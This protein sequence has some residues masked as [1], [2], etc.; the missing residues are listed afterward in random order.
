MTNEG[1]NKL[2]SI[3]TENKGSKHHISK[4]SEL[5]LNLAENNMVDDDFKEQLFHIIRKKV[6]S[7]SD[8]SVYGTDYSDHYALFKM[9]KKGIGVKKNPKAALNSLIKMVKKG[10]KNAARE[11]IFSYRDGNTELNIKANKEKMIDWCF[12]TA[13]YNCPL[14]LYF[15]A[16]QSAGKEVPPF[17]DLGVSKSL[18][19]AIKCL[20]EL[21]KY[22][23][24]D[25]DIAWDFDFTLRK[26]TIPLCE[27][28]DEHNL[29]CDIENDLWNYTHHTQLKDGSPDIVGYLLNLLGTLYLELNDYQNAKET[30]KKAMTHESFPAIINLSEM[31]HYGLGSSKDEEQAFTLKKRIADLVLYEKPSLKFNSYND[32]KL[33]FFEIVISVAEAYRYGIGV[34]QSLSTALEYYSQIKK[35]FWVLKSYDTLQKEIT[36]RAIDE[37]IETVKSKTEVS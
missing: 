27:E 14:G 29:I 10:D 34:Q 19:L 5:A 32:E 9:Y 21:T 36:N 8:P 26:Y 25:C 35:D 31:Y 13:E 17:Y 12:K 24:I 23:Y 3:I 6:K 16:H 15:L 18:P 1:L 28:I 7:E 37:I 11:I 2:L 30:F 22:A 20:K 33:N 4:L